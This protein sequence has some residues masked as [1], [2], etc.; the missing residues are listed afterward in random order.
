VVGP[1]TTLRLV[2]IG[3]S[4]SDASA[5]PAPRI[6]PAPAQQRI[7]RESRG[8]RLVYL[9]SSQPHE[10]GGRPPSR[11]HASLD[12]TA[13]N[14][15]H[16]D[17][18]RPLPEKILAKTR[19]ARRYQPP[20]TTPPLGL[21]AAAWASR[22]APFHAENRHEKCSG[23]SLSAQAPTPGSAF[24][25]PSAIPR[26]VGSRPD[27]PARPRRPHGHAGQPNGRHGT[28]SRLSGRRQ[29]R[30]P[31]LSTREGNCGVISI[32]LKNKSCYGRRSRRITACEVMSFKVPYY[33]LKKRRV[34][35][36]GVRPPAQPRSRWAVCP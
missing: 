32:I 10:D 34:G 26:L 5:V 27:L 17:P 13:S 33:Y 19:P 16:N 22:S 35:G 30:R 23:G 20:H 4:P 36:A 24:Q 1:A 28:S 6:G 21:P 25:R 2:M 8:G 14:P 9:S 29:N 18:A 31:G 3:W 7:E 15:C 12:S 11:P